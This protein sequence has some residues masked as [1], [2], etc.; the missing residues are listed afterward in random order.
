[1]GC[2]ASTRNPA[3]LVWECLAVG[4]F[5]LGESLPTPHMWVFETLF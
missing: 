2:A 5:L 4:V 1:M 3:S